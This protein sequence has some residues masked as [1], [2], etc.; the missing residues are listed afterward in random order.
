[1]RHAGCPRSIACDGVVAGPH[2]YVPVSAFEAAFHASSE[3]QTRALELE[4]AVSD[5]KVWF[6]HNLYIYKF[7]NFYIYKSINLG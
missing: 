1:M 2:K 6:L 5:L 7:I 4:Q 3:G